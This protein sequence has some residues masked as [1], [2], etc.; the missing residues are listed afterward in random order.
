MEKIN[1][2]LQALKKENEALN[3]VVTF[4][5]LE[6]QIES[7][8]NQEESPFSKTLI[9]VKDNI[10]TAGIKT[11]ASS[12]LLDD[13]V[14]FYDATVVKKLKEAGML[15]FAKTSLDELAMGGNNLS[16]YSGPV[17]NPYD[18][19]RIA[20]GSSGGSAALVGS[21]ILR[22]ALGTDTGDS[23]RKPA[24]YLSIVGVKPTYG[25]V[26]RFGVIP[27]APTLDHVG[28]FTRDVKEA[29]AFLKVIAGYD[30]KDPTSSKEPVLDYEKYLTG[31]VNGKVFGVLMNVYELLDNKHRQAL[32][33]LFKE[34]SK[35]GAIIRFI[36]IDEKLME[37]MFGTY[38]VIA[39]SE[40]TSSSANLDGLRFGY[41]ANG[42]SYQETILKTRSEGFSY[43]VKKRLLFGG[44]ALEASEGKLYQQALKVRRLIVEEFARAFE[45]IDCL[46]TIGHEAKPA[47]IEGENPPID[48]KKYLIIENAMV[49]ANFNGFPSV[50]VPLTFIDKLP[51]GINITAKPFQEGE[52][53]NYSYVIEQIVKIN[54]ELKQRKTYEL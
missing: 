51:V 11:T 46:L 23:I 8:K 13:F 22:Y 2:Q 30:E 1:L 34:L 10:C 44:Y 35:K 47:L 19:R 52:L 39:N 14:P 26:S 20:G 42:D 24:S 12:R 41:Q 25:R 4:I 17:R 37:A 18:L 16:A 53:F 32:D 49:F 3:A 38:F 5:D 28:Y 48:L 31:D 33:D 40:A 27:Y 6:E 21:G 29:A 45:E 7:L 43:P 36:K 15:L 54:P 50:T 9:A